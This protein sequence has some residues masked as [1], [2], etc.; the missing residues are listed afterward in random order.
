VFVARA[1][2]RFSNEQQSSIKYSGLLLLFPFSLKCDNS[3]LLRNTLKCMKCGYVS[4]SFEFFL[5]ISLSIN[6]GM[7]LE[8][9]LDKFTE[10]ESM[11]EEDGWRCSKCNQIAAAK[12]QITLHQLAPVLTI[13]LKRF[14]YEGRKIN[15]SITFREQ[16][17]TA[18]AL[19][20]VPDAP[21]NYRLYA[22]IVHYGETVFVGHYAAFI[23]ANG[24]WWFFDDNKVTPV[25]SSVVLQQPAYMLFYER[26]QGHRVMRNLV[27][28]EED[29]DISSLSAATMDSSSINSLQG[30]KPAEGSYGRVYADIRSNTLADSGSAKPA[31]KQKKTQPNQLCPCGSGKKFKFCHAKK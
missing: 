25:H 26:D 5:D 31:P 16:I 23:L 19:S 30:A 4:G 29:I 10:I 14:D 8:E 15:K 27:H 20:V 7:S 9:A 24:V 21:V 12:K 2:R 1:R 3:G 13:A 18:R 6:D 28:A 11:N 17:N 22:V